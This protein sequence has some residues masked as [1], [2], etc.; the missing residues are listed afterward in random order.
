MSSSV[1]SATRPCDFGRSQL[2]NPALRGLTEVDSGTSLPS[3][4]PIF[5]RGL[6]VTTQQTGAR[7]DSGS[8]LLD[9]DQGHIKIILILC[10]LTNPISYK[11]IQVDLNLT[12]NPR[13]FRL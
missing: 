11:T 8:V 13:Q 6:G 4:V 3:G 2:T 7:L 10:I 5:R 12:C 9:Q 1:M